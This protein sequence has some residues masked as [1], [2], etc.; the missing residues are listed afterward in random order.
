MATTG[1]KGL[2]V[3]VQVASWEGGVCQHVTPPWV[4]QWSRSA[5]G[6]WLPSRSARPDEAVAFAEALAKVGR[7]GLLRRPLRFFP[8]AQVLRFLLPSLLFPSLHPGLGLL[9]L[10]VTGVGSRPYRPRLSPGLGHAHHHPVFHLCPLLAQACSG[11]HSNKVSYDP[12]VCEIQI[13]VGL[14]THSR[15]HAAHTHTHTQWQGMVD[16]A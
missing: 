4:A 12:H 3:L 5:F 6:C 7:W 15:M 11:H 14:T 10:P 16:G 2:V 9:A 13:H 8:P 1:P